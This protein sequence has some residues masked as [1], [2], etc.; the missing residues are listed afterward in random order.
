MRA[1]KTRD[2]EHLPYVKKLKDLGL[3]SV[4]KRKWTGGLIT[5]VKWM[6]PGSFQWSTVTVQGVAGKDFYIG[7]SF[8]I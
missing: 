7:S 5:G 1:T 4:D 2:L 8:Q 3:F 6:R